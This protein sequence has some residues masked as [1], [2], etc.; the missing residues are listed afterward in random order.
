MAVADRYVLLLTSLPWPGTDATATR[1]PVNRLRLRDRLRWLDPE[2]AHTVQRIES[3]L[4]WER[5]QLGRDDEQEIAAV[6]ALLA[7]LREPELRE[8]VLRR[9]EMRLLVASLRRRQRGRE[10]LPVVG[11]SRSLLAQ[12]A[13]RWQEP[14]FGLAARFPWLA[15]AARLVAAG[16][17]VGMER[18][19]TT[20]AW[21]QI[22][23]A[24]RGHAFDL[25]AV[26][27]YVLRWS[28]AERRQLEDRGAATVRFRSMVADGLGAIGTAME[29]KS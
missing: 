23:A 13:R 12:V 17:P 9:F 26:V 19:L 16:D 7:E 10:A 11:S 14:A 15:D 20:V 27:V 22:D 4:Q 18:L 2:D 3:V 29:S 1:P 24:G 8:L 21:R 28:L 25:V 5:L 6:D